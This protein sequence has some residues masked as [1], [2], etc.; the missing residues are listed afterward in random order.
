M[1]AGIVLPTNYM[2]DYS[3]MGLQVDD[4]AQTIG[5]LRDNGWRV[6]PRADSA[7]LSF[8]GHPPLPQVLALLKAKGLNGSLTD[9]VSQVYQG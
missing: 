5:I 2:A 4:L 8:T 7:E 6:E 9:L 1:P 3:V